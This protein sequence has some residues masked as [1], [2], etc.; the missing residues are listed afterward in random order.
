MTGLSRS[1]LL[2]IVKSEDPISGEN[3]VKT[4]M[5]KQPGAKRGILLI[6][7][8]SLLAYFNEEARRQGGLRFAEH[9]HNPKDH[10]VDA[11]LSDIDLY[12]SF[13]SDDVTEEAWLTGNLST[14]AKRVRL[15]RE[16]GL[17]EAR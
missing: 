11:V 5:H 2:Q 8:E 4:V 13:V 6:N 7:R 16:F 10:S 9:V 17:L 3:R 14:R 1:T 12:R 15:M